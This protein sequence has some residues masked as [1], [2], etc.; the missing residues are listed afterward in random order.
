MWWPAVSRSC[1]TLQTITG[2]HC[3]QA[4]WT[5]AGQTEYKQ[6][7]DGSHG[8]AFSAWNTGASLQELF[9]NWKSDFTAGFV[10]QY[11]Q[12]CHVKLW[13]RMEDKGQQWPMLAPHR[14]QGSTVGRCQ[15][16]PGSSKA[17]HA[18]VQLTYLAFPQDLFTQVITDLCHF[19]FLV[20]PW[21]NSGFEGSPG[22]QHFRKFWG[23]CPWSS[24]SCLVGKE[25]YSAK[26]SKRTFRN[27]LI[28]HKTS[29]TV[30]FISKLS[31][32][33]TSYKKYL[34]GS[35]SWSP[36]IFHLCEDCKACS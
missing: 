2:G 20:L 21:S 35:G 28:S 32:E 1:G 15:L 31:S 13:D 10:P 16:W 9:Q 26:M 5:W 23:W 36:D 30:Y 14:A 4:S 22:G 34:A 3:A 27:F 25:C 18:E 11:P 19:L 33:A 29:A 7:L 24:C 6:T 8:Q 12:I 17:A